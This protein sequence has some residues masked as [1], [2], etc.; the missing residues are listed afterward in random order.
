MT[1]PLPPT[2]QTD[3]SPKRS[4]AFSSRM[5]VPATVTVCAFVIEPVV[6]RAQ[7]F[8]IVRSPVVGEMPV[9]L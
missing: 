3:A 2:R 9:K 1:R 7:P 4:D 6:K 8:V 5:P